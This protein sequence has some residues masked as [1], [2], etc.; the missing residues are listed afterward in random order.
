MPPR[1]ANSTITKKDIRDKVKLYQRAWHGSVFGQEFERQLSPIVV[2]RNLNFSKTIS[3]GLG[4]FERPG[5]SRSLV[6]LV[7]MIHMSKIF[8]TAPSARE[9]LSATGLL[10]YAQD[11]RFLKKHKEILGECEFHSV[12]QGVEQRINESSIFY[13]VGLALENF[14]L[15]TLNEKEPLMIVHDIPSEVTE[16]GAPN[17]FDV[18]L[19]SELA[20]KYHS[21]NLVPCIDTLQSS[22]FLEPWVYSDELQ[23]FEWANNVSDALKKVKYWFHRSCGLKYTARD[24]DIDLYS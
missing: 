21:V 6:R 3:M 17:G 2:N 7:Q 23:G 18:G 8:A 5:G 16:G 24:A 4:R 19:Y 22:S 12:D 10:G 20:D 14:P 13:G 15:Q 11:E 9:L 1:Q